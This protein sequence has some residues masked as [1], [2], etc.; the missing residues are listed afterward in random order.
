MARGAGRFADD[1]EAAA[2]LTRAVELAPKYVPA[3]FDLGNVLFAQN[4]LPDA[5][6]GF[7]N[8]YVAD[9]IIVL[10]WR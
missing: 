9:H 10:L 7:T 3:H 6:T 1:A 4:K 8:C 5:L 2:E